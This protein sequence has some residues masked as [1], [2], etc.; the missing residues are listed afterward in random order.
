MQQLEKLPL[1]GFYR[2]TVA[3]GTEDCE[4]NTTY[5]YDEVRHRLH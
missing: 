4:A 3:E 2:S 1:D 5:N